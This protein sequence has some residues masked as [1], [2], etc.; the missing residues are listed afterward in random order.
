[1][2]EA[3]CKQHA[4]ATNLRRTACSPVQEAWHKH[5]PKYVE[6]SVLLSLQPFQEVKMVPER[7]ARNPVACPGCPMSNQSKSLTVVHVWLCVGSTAMCAGMT[8]V[9]VDWKTMHSS[10]C[11][12]SALLP[13][14][15]HSQQLQHSFLWLYLQ[16]TTSMFSM[17]CSSFT[18][19]CR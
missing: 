6:L 4:L 7:P 12:L 8:L 3:L 19:L 14:S 5:Q 11:I 17:A 13:C 2:Y 16:L 1:M 15:E 9:K 18:L 10:S